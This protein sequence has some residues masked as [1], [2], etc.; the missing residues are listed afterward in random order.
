MEKEELLVLETYL[1]NLYHWKEELV[2]A[3]PGQAANGILIYIHAI[4]L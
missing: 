3:P 1:G 2:M 4:V